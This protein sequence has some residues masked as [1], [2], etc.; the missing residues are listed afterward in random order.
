MKKQ[1]INLI[2]D[3]MY[4]WMYV[5]STLKA[6][7]PHILH[8]KILKPLLG[9]YTFEIIRNNVNDILTVTDEELISAMQFYA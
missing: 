3:I 9:N 7:W 4:N 5:L 8:Y 1:T 2:L 6:Q